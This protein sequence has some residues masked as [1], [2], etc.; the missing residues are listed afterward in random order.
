VLGFVGLSVPY[1]LPEVLP[2]TELGWRLHPDGW[3]RGLA[4]EGGRA[5]LDW[6]FGELRIRRVIS[7]T[8]PDNHGSRRVSERLGLQV[9]AETTHPER[10]IP[11]LVYAID[12]YGEQ[13]VRS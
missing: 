12:A 10:Q 8:E 11:L 7:I 13:S 2:A 6:A 9:E 3:G 5:A 1:F 4:T